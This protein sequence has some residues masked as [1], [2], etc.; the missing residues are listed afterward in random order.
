[1]RRLGEIFAVEKKKRKKIDRSLVVSGVETEA[2][3]K[4]V[5]SLHRLSLYHRF[6]AGYYVGFFQSDRS[7][8]VH[9]HGQREGK[10]RHQKIR[11]QIVSKNNNLNERFNDAARV[12]QL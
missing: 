3:S 11:R 4:R 12:N 7:H 8:S 1:M 5:T 6:Y 10:K 9:V 2:R